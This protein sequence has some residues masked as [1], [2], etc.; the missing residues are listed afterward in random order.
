MQISILKLDTPKMRSIEAARA[1]AAFV[2]VLMHAANLMEVEHFSG[3]IGLGRIFDF[4]YVGVDFFFVLSGFII[5]Y[6][7]FTDIGRVE[8]VPRYLW[9]RF[10]RIYP[11]YWVILLLVIAIT[12]TGRLA[13]G[14]GVGW[15]IGVSDIAGTIFLLMGQGK[16][17]YVGV[18]WSLQYEVVFYIAFC[19]LLVNVRLGIAVFVAWG[20]YVFAKVLNLVQAELPLALSTAYCLQFLFGVVVGVAARRYVLRTPVATLLAAVLV[21]VAAVVFE[22]YGP[23]ARHSDE[24][25]I[26][27]GLASAAL[28]ATLVAMENRQALHT[29]SWLA[30]IG[31]VSYSIYLGHIVFINLTYMTL[32][33]VG[34]YHAL[35]EALVFTTAVGVALAATILIGLYIELPLVR[36]L[37]DRRLGRPQTMPA[38]A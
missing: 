24:G 37:K 11:I 14:K 4:G 8:R 6:V 17:Q 3:H 22:V 29:P 35:P 26:I 2:V 33:K 21:F 15:E 32:L 5:T 16:P 38:T 12:T 13:T 30:R 34:L 20:I 9:R 28:L 1:I 27:L 36:T 25:R 7:H 18:A 31:S 10:S 19:L 23:L